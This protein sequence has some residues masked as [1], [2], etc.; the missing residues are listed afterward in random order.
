MLVVFAVSVV[1]ASAASAAT[2]E[3]KPVPTKKKLTGTTKGT[4]WEFDSGV[5][6]ISCTKS[7]TTGEITTAT[8]V[9]KVVIVYTGCTDSGPGESNC[10]ANS[11]GAKAGEIV[12]KS[13]G[14]ELGTVAVAEAASGVGLR[15]KPETKTKLFELAENKC[16]G[17]E[18]ITG[19]VAAEVAVIGK[20]QVTNKLVLTGA[21]Q[22]QSIKEIKLDSGVVEKPRLLTSALEGGF[23]STHE[24]LTFEEA[25]EVS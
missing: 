2:P 11:P 17:G 20:K 12:T 24:E 13:L 3:F 19:S 8:T 7:S 16:F 15:L 18:S 21:G 23:M 1:A 4:I 5:I 22:N 9:G 6:T 14:G 10:P 25:L